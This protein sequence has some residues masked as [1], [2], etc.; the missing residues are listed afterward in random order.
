MI[1]VEGFKNLYR[2]EKTGAIVNTDSA[3]Y[4]QHMKNKKIRES[5]KNEIDQIKND[6]S[7]IKDILMKILSDKSS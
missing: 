7:E 2:D 3:E 6:I 5:Q 4:N 1:R